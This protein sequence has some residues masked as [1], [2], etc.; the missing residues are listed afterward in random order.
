[1]NM[2]KGQEATAMRSRGWVG[3]VK[4]GSVAGQRVSFQSSVAAPAARTPES[5][6]NCRRVFLYISSLLL[7]KSFVRMN[8]LRD[9]SEV[10]HQ[11]LRF[12]ILADI[13]STPNH[14]CCRNV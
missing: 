1:M 6:R 11:D 14:V 7:S 9:A 2:R 10:I 3:N 13:H 8:P 12:A 5:L 4:C